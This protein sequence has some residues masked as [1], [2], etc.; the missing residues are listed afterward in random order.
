MF[1]SIATTHQPATDLGFLLHKHPDRLHQVELAFGKALI[2][3][4]EAD[5]TRCEAALV[6]DIDP[7]G[8]VRGKGNTEGLLDQYV[9]DRPYS[10]SSFLSVALNK[11]F[12]T[13]MAG[14][15]NARQDLADS[16]IPLEAVVTPLPL[17]GGEKL[18]RA[19]RQSW[20]GRRFVCT[21]NA[22]RGGPSQRSSQPS[23]RAC[24]GDGRRQAL[25]GWRG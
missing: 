19:D 6:L 25:L 3:Y 5:A 2:L 12:R 20:Q 22:Q 8:L 11:A 18:V 7:V 15:C 1:L 23:V 14:I 16:A 10:A 9:N 4:P 17:R 13:A 24:S 21:N